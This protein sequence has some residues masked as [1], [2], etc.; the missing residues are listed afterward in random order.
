MGD[1]EHNLPPKGIRMI[2][3]KKPPLA[4][5]IVERCGKLL[6]GLR[7]RSWGERVGYALDPD[8]HVLALAVPAVPA[9]KLR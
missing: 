7:G 4:L 5:K 2:S 3:R 8:G 6:D 9:G 1:T